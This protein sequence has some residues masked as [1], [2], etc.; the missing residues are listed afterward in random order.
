MQW[1]YQISITRPTGNQAGTGDSQSQQ[2]PHPWTAFIITYLLL[3]S[4]MEQVQLGLGTISFAFH[5]H[6][7]LVYGL[8]N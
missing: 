2:T 8:G 5:S 3:R 6:I 4:N 1:N 7:W